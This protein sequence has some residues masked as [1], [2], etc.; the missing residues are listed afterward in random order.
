MKTVIIS[1]MLAATVVDVVH[2]QCCVGVGPVL[3]ANTASACV[4]SNGTVDAKWTLMPAAGS[5]SCA[6]VGDGFA[7]IAY[8]CS[9]AT[10]TIYG[11]HCATPIIMAALYQEVEFASI[12]CSTV[13]NGSS[14]TGMP[15]WM[16]LFLVLAVLGR[17][18][19]F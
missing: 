17:N 7:C 5:A 3:P 14:R 4:S 10:L 13:S 9:N 2:S 16:V 11:R 6:S 15:R 12:T 1:L 8:K 19:S 18:W